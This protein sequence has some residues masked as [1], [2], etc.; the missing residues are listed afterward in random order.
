[1]GHLVGHD[2]LELVPVEFL[3][4]AGSNGD[5]GVLRISAR[6]KGVGGRVVNYVD[7]RHSKAAS[8]DHLLDDVVEDGSFFVGYFAGAGGAED[9]PGAAVVGNEAGDGADDEGQGQAEEGS[10]WVP[11]PG[12]T[13]DVPEYGDEGDK[14]GDEQQAV[15]LVGGDAV[16]ESTLESVYVHLG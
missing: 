2:A 14:A 1:M 8:Q 11:D 4:Q 16:P 3:Q 13:D 12:E 10:R 7:L 9:H 6:G 5:G 15:P